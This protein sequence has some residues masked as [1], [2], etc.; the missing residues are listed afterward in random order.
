MS[1][2]RHPVRFPR[3]RTEIHAKFR[4]V[5]ADLVVNAYA[6]VGKNRIKAAK[7]A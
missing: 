5:S 1:D 3:A 6:Q 7:V 2:I 4:G